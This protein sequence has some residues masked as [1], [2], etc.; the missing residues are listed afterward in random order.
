MP[1][2][3]HSRCMLIAVLIEHLLDAR[4]CINYL[5][6]VFSFNLFNDDTV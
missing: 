3:K 4:Y 6:Y 1:D 2:N 5:M